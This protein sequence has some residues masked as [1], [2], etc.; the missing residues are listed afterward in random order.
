MKK[1]ILLITMAGYFMSC[2]KESERGQYAIE[3]TPPGEITSPIVEN[4]AGGAIITYVIPDDEDLLYV[5]AIYTLDNGEKVE[6]K[7]SAYTNNLIIEGFG[8]SREVGVDLIAG[9]RSKNESKPVRVMAHP[10]DAPIYAVYNSIR[11]SEDFGGVR[12]IWKNPDEA[13]VVISITTIDDLGNT[14]TADNFYTKSRAGQGSVRGYAHEARVFGVSVHDRWGNVTDTLKGTFTPL[15]EQRIEPKDKFV[16]WNPMEIPY[17]QYSPAYSIE[18]LWDDN[19]LTRYLFFTSVFP[20]S[21][22][23]DMGQTAVFSRFRA[24]MDPGQLYGGQSVESF[25]LW[26]TNN[27]DVGSDFSGWEKLGEYRFTKPSE[28]G[29]S[30]QEDQALGLSGED[31]TVDP[32]APAVR[33]MRLVVKKTWG[34]SQYVTLADLRFWGQVR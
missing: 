6:Q 15:F 2:Y 25:E 29:G 21:V 22:T 23:F 18:Q 24:Y 19:P 20:F 13:E 8:K 30:S 31:F 11:V 33:Y 7:A 34:N 14:V 12:I 3:K 4:V 26:G 28:K 5:K 27:P 9:D 1:Y 10:L 17:T 16:R 32:N